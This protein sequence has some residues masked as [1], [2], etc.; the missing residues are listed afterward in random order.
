[1]ASRHNP[2]RRRGMVGWSR[3]FKKQ[4]RRLQAP[5]NWVGE[6]E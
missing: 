1:M 2:L 5:T 3:A 6:E 4:E